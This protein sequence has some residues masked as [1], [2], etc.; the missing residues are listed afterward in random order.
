MRYHSARV[1]LG[2]C[3]L[4]AVA[5]AQAPQS[6]P[7]SA[8]LPGSNFTRESV[9]ASNAGY[10]DVRSSGSG[11]LGERQP[12]DRL[13]EPQDPDYT[14]VG[15]FRTNHGEFMDLRERYN[16]QIELRARAL[17]NARV[18]DEPGSFDML[19][20]D[21]DAEF[22]TLVSTEGYLLFGA[23]YKGRRYL[24]SSAFG[25]AGNSGTFADQR[26]F[27]DETLVGAGLKFGFGVFLSDNWL[28]EAQTSPG[29]WSDLDDTLHHDD[30]DF[31][32]SAMFTARALDR[33]FFKFGARYNQV[34]EEAPWLPI[35]GFS[36]EITDG[37]RLDVLAPESIE[38]SWWPTTSTGFLLGGYVT[39]AEYHMHTAEAL[40]QRADLRVQEAIVYLGLVQRMNENLSFEMRG[41]MTVAGDYKLTTGAN[42]FNIVEGAL[43]QGVYAEIMLGINF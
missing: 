9:D 29:A 39:G 38:M 43:D 2:A 20:Y 17:P 30:F 28:F 21:F 24:T 35:L 33:F 7:R 42:G 14:L 18:N 36:W 27:G 13:Y 3:L 22:P 16:P 10:D 31:P 40:N 4:A 25:S 5:A 15:Q 6:P 41:G 26:S 19:G 8:P 32:S 34:F 11:L 23:Y 12:G 1:V 37:F